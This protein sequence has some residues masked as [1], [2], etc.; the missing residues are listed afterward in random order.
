VSAELAKLRY[1]HLPRWTAGAVLAAAVLVGVG[2]LIF[3][4][5]DPARYASTP[6]FAMSVTLTIAAIV[7]G[8]WI[9]TLEFASGT[10]QRTLTAEPDRGKVLLAKLAVLLLGLIGLGVI[11]VGTTIGLSDLAAS[12]AAADVDSG[13]VARQVAAILPPA[14]AAGV[15]GFGFGL[16]AGSTG[17]GIAAAFAFVFVLDGF[18]TQVPELGDWTFGRVTGDVQAK[19]AGD[20]AAEHALVASLAATIAWSALIL[21]PGWVRILR[22]DLK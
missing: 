1:L 8:V 12:R 18:L 11:A 20:A 2:L 4:P 16:L 3:P 7:F 15:V 9:A 5:T 13:D 10:W 22:S 14:I 6:T 19:I 21:A 17:G